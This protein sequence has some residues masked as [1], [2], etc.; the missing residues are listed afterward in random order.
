M[1]YVNLGSIK[2]TN[3]EERTHYISGTMVKKVILSFE[4]LSAD[5]STLQTASATDAFANMETGSTCLLYDTS[6]LYKYNASNKTW[7]EL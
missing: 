4:G 6:K 5:F 1:N 3:S 2:V 7:Y